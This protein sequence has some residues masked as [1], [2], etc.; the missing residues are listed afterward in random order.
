MERKIMTNLSIPVNENVL[1]HISFQASIQK[2]SVEMFLAHFLENSFKEEPSP[3]RTLRNEVLQKGL[4]T[5][6]LDEI[7]AQVKGNRGEKG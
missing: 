3:F 6:S 5:L 4:N 2:L 1:K 7:N